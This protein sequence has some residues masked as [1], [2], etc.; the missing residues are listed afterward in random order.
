MY[1]ANIIFLR[2]HVISRTRN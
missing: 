1:K 2:Q